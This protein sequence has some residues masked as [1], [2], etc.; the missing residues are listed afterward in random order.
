MKPREAVGWR[1]K[2]WDWVYELV[3][4]GWAGSGLYQ[5][6]VW[7]WRVKW[8]DCEEEE[9]EDLMRELLRERREV[10]VLLVEG[11]KILVVPCVVMQRRVLGSRVRVRFMLSPARR[12]PP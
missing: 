10:L 2:V 3:A 7:G 11:L 4:K 6:A 9:E 1:T 12:P 8:R 5:R